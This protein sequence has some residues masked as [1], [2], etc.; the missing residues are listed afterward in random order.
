M[1]FRRQEGPHS[2]C[3][4]RCSVATLVALLIWCVLLALAPLTARADTHIHERGHVLVLH[5]YGPD[6]TWT[7]SQ[8]E[9][10]DAVFSPLAAEYEL[11]IE[12]LDAVHNPGLLKEPLLLELLRAKLSTQKFQVVLTSDNAAFDFARAHR[13]ELFPGVPIVFMGLNGYDD[14]ML[15]GESGITGVAEDG[16]MFGTLQVLLRLAPQTR[17]IVFPGMADDLTYRGIRATLTKDL[18]TLPAQ[19]EAEFREYPHVDAL[20][21]DL[22]TLPPDSALFTIGNMRTRD[23]LGISSQ[24]AAELMSS[25]ASV[26]LFTS[27]DFLVGH[28]AVGGSVISGVEQGRLAAEIAVQVMHGVRPEAIPVRRGAGKTLLFDHRQLVRFDIPASELPS[29]AVVRFSP[30]STLSISREAA[31]IAGVSFVLLLGVSASLVIAVLQR[32]RSEEQVRA[33]N[34][35]LEQRVAERTSALEQANKELESFAYSVSHDLRA[36]LRHIDGFLALLKES[37]EPSL[38]DQ[39]LHYMSTIADAARRMST[40]IDDLLAFSRMGRQDMSKTPVDLNALVAD[41]IRGLAPEAAGRDIDWRIADLPVVAGDRAMLRIV[42]FNLISN[43]LKY[44]SKR[45]QARI[46]IG[47]QPGEAGETV[48]FVRDNG[49][50]FDMRFKDKLFGVFQRLHR[51]DEFEGTG[52]GLANVARIIARHGGKVWAQGQVDQGATF[53]FALPKDNP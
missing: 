19:V 27:W 25:T 43:A 31:W 36:P 8:Q 47:T 32:R 40:L 30:Q 20:L 49:A 33:L 11:R 41:V 14:A 50:G 21:E 38:D 18:A 53:S 16:D 51:V 1:T 5:S 7:R 12:Y 28:G 29:G 15:Q 23:G 48:V 45:P 6:F 4:P 44:T 26:P 42:L 2:L 13:A 46:E 9:G 17:R 52:I 10:V 22:K 3:P 34:Q 35:A 37:V 39:S 24:R